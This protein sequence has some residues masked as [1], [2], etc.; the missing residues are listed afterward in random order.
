MSLAKLIEIAKSAD[1]NAIVKTNNGTSSSA[2]GSS[3]GTS[4]PRHIIEARRDALV[5]TLYSSFIKV[6][7]EP[8]DDRVLFYSVKGKANML[9]LASA[10]NGII[11]DLNT[12][13]FVC[14]PPMSL[15]DV[16][17][18]KVIDNL[19][20][21]VYDVYPAVDG[22]TVNVYYYNG[23]WQIATAK[24]ISNNSKKWY[25]LTWTS[26][27]QTIFDKFDV[28][29]SALQKNRTYSFTIQ[30]PKFHPFTNDYGLNVISI[31]NNDKFNESLD[32]NLRKP[33]D[34]RI[35][36]KVGFQKRL[37]NMNIGRINKYNK[38]S[39]EHY[40][41]TGSKNFGY[42]LRRKDCNSFGCDV[43][44]PSALSNYIVD[45]IYDV[46]CDPDINRTRYINLYNYL[47]NDGLYL[48]LFPAFENDFNEI[49][50]I[51]QG[52]LEKIHSNDRSVKRLKSIILSNI[53]F[54]DNE[55]EIYKTQVSYLLMDKKHT[56]I[57][58]NLIS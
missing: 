8:D 55:T 19:A 14:V 34:K 35:I 12:L 46:K 6:A 15:T 48:R 39:I 56:E 22:T 49:N 25:G 23:K 29:L 53:E 57:I 42:L 11:L 51:I 47:N 31:V 5:K 4:T 20:S 41:N 24:G 32:N 7:Y 18:K 13:K 40:L 16:V 38:S 1:K 58:Y 26:V 36:P 50:I 44:I 33:L 10:L 3:S 45:H 9:G 37:D 52:V 28:K 27:L 43:F 54:Q 17:N 21:G 30:H 2:A